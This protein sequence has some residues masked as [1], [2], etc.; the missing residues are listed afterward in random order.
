MCRLCVKLKSGKGTGIADH[1]EYDKYNGDHVITV[2]IP[3]EIIEWGLFAVMTT[4]ESFQLHK[5]KF[6]PLCG[7]Y[8]A[9]KYRKQ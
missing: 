1:E 4:E 3:K 2:T 6:C 5:L 7:K 8:I 9:K